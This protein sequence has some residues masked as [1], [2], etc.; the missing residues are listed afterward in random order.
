MPD[1]IIPGEP[2]PVV[3]ELT[4]EP[5]PQ[6][7]VAEPK[8]AS[9]FKPTVLRLTKKLAR[10]LQPVIVPRHRPRVRRVTRVVRHIDTWSVFKIALLLW[11]R[12]D[13]VTS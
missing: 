1:K 6:E 5:E 13:F 7:S 10:S 3:D 9:A 11:L 8:T 12:Q 4:A 2:D